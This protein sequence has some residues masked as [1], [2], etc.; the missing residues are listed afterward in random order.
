MA[1]PSTRLCHLEDRSA[2]CANTCANIR[3][4][5]IPL[6]VAP[7]P[8]VLTLA[9]AQ[10]AKPNKCNPS[11]LHKE[12]DIVVLTEKFGASNVVV[13]LQV[14]FVQVKHWRESLSDESPPPSEQGRPGLQPRRSKELR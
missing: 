14:I 3:P 13:M 7:F 4:C 11:N 5:A 6:S 12:T 1:P 9:A 8:P 2:T 10:H